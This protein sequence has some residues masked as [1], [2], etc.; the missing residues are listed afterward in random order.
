MNRFKKIEKRIE[1]M[2]DKCEIDENLFTINLK[3]VNIQRLL[4]YQIT[5]TFN[6]IACFKNNMVVLDGSCTGTG[7]TYTSICVCSELG[8]RP[9]IICPLSIIS[10]WKTVCEYF[11]VHPI[12]IVNLETI[13]A[14]KASYTKKDNLS[15]VLKIV[16]GKY[17]WNFDKNTMV[18]IDEVHKC[19][20]H[21]SHNGEI[22][23]SLKNKTKI[24][25]LS[26][27]VADKPEFFKVYGYMLGFYKNIS[28]S[29]SWINAI[30][31]EENNRLGDVTSPLYN[32][33]YP[34]KGSRMSL[35]DIGTKF[36]KNQISVDCY[37]LNEKDQEKMNQFYQNLKKE[38]DDK[39]NKSSSLLAVS[40][41]LLSRQKLELLKVPIVIDLMEKYLENNKSIV[42]FVN[43]INTLKRLI[44]ILIQQKKQYSVLHGDLSLEERDIE[45][46]KFQSNHTK[47]IICTMQV[48]S[49]SISLH[50]IHGDA[51]RVSLL[52]PSFSSIDL[53]QAL[54]RTYRVGLKTPTIQKI[55]LCNDPNEKL[56]CEKI[57][58][59]LR[60]NTKLSEND[61]QN[62]VTKNLLKSIEN[63]NVEDLY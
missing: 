1:D 49:Q 7:K 14:R 8:A 50:D 2:F 33:L 29:K 20:N 5:H 25:M 62:K 30:L 15:N 40:T 39:D 35:D 10:V 32:K 22:L 43:F 13:K 34:E 12:A 24:L 44:E 61:T 59:K 27:T 63:E 31:R 11:D 9:L 18:I 28:K 17:D 21:K 48:G 58:E 23:L 16:N 57:K 42:I 45:I 53:I 3:K 47:I 6:L 60:F 46:N 38:G 4:D 55:I 41:I 36:P 51:P 37:T 26:A 54:G 19:K 52:L 56:I